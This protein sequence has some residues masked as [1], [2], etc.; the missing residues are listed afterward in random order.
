M[1]MEL[2]ERTDY[3]KRQLDRLLERFEGN[4]PPENGRDREF[5]KLVKEETS[6]IYSNLELWEEGALAIVKER[7]ASVHPQQ[8]T[9]TRENM[10]LLL[11]HSYYIDVRRKRYME[12]YKSIHY[13]F[14]ML[15]NDLDQ[16]LQSF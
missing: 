8:V 10:E 4:E 3:L 12:L 16:T 11:M 15:L 6:P 5:F 13:V 2:K 14:D 1:E 7:K 9:S